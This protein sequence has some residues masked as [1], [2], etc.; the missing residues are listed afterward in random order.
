MSGAF[1]VKVKRLLGFLDIGSDLFDSG[2]LTGTKELLIK[3]KTAGVSLCKPGHLTIHVSVEFKEVDVRC[4]N[5][6]SSFGY[7]NSCPCNSCLSDF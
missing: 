3:L 7:I 2:V 4:K 1:Y 6:L 5:L